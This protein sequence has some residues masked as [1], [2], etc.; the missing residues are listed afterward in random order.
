MGRLPETVEGG[1]IVRDE[2]GNPTGFLSM[3]NEF[4][5]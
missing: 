5:P 3:I 4:Y 2:N 1:N